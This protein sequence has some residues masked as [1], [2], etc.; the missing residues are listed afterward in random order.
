MHDASSLLLVIRVSLLTAVPVYTPSVVSKLLVQVSTVTLPLPLGV[1]DHHTDWPPG[2]PAFTGSP[3]SLDAAMF[4][5]LTVPP[6]GGS[7]N[8][9]AKL[10]LLGPVKLPSVQSLTA[11][12]HSC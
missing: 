2:L 10:S 3:D 1:H 7:A 5:P 4:V 11:L 9:L 12:L 8:A 6:C